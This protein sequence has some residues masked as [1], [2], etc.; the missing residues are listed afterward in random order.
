MRGSWL[1]Q[2]S[3][4]A[5]SCCHHL[6]SPPHIP[7]RLTYDRSPVAAAYRTF[8]NV[9]GVVVILASNNT[10]LLAAKEACLAPMALLN[11]FLGNNTAGLSGCTCDASAAVAQL[12][13]TA[14]DSVLGGEQASLLELEQGP[15]F[16]WSLP[17]SGGLP[18]TCSAPVTDPNVFDLYPT[19]NRE[20]LFQRGKWQAPSMNP[21]PS[22][23]HALSIPCSSFQPPSC[24]SEVRATSP[25]VTAG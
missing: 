15:S 11:A 24:G 7:P 1:G 16:L 12:N 10:N 19:S 21:A 20:W 25:L 8:A 22:P 18:L 9:G 14:A 17:L 23:Q 3:N 6:E 5:V 2:G 4:D 13:T